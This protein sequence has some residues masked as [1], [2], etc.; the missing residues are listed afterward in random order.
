MKK[1]ILLLPMNSQLLPTGLYDNRQ[2]FIFIRLHTLF[3]FGHTLVRDTVHSLF[4][5]RD[6]DIIA[7]DHSLSK[8]F[9]DTHMPRNKVKGRTWW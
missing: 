6:G 1:L 5:K 7:K 2:G 3:R 8:V 9:F 4:I